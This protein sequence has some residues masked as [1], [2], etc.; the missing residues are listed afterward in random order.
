MGIKLIWASTVSVL[1]RIA[2]C[3]YLRLAPFHKA[4]GP[5]IV[6]TLVL[7]YLAL[8]FQDASHA[9]ITEKVPVIKGEILDVKI[10]EDSNGIHG[11]GKNISAEVVIAAP[12]DSQPSVRII[13]T[14]SRISANLCEALCPICYT[15]T[16]SPDTLQ[17]ALTCVSRYQHPPHR[18]LHR[19]YLRTL[20]QGL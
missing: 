3:A 1:F 17:N 12:V 19:L 5:V 14:H 2:V 18:I 16:L 4:L 10:T 9:A 7:Y 8:F 6:V 20:P 13:I 15:C 11:K